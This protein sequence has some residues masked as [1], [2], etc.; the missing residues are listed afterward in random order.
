MLRAVTFAT[1]DDGWFGALRASCARQGVP[2]DVLGWGEAWQGFLHKVHGV[3]AYVGGLAP[4]T[5]VLFVDAY[6]TLVLC[7]AAEILRRFDSLVGGTARRAERVVL[8]VEN[9]HRDP[10]MGAIKRIPFGA[11]GSH[12]LNSGV[13]MG[14]AGRLRELLERWTAAADP[15]G[16]GDDQKALNALCR[17][18][19][20]WFAAHATYDVDG[21]LVVNAC[22]SLT[23]YVFGGGRFP[24]DALWNPRIGG[25]SPVVLHMPGCLDL[26]PVCAHLGLPLGR[27]RALLPLL[28]RN[29]GREALAAAAGGLL[30]ALVIAAAVVARRATR[31]RGGPARRTHDSFLF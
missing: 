25:R 4:E 28:L 1:R 19:G 12:T 27:R 31:R 13:Y 26:N 7:D 11:C 21:L 17:T 30:L 9:P 6:D 20:A 16:G 8:G 10:L 23:D 29:F 15:G 22:A 2:L 14:S 5:L 3:R 18:D 24:A